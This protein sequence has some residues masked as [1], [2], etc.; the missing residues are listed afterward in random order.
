MFTMTASRYNVLKYYEY[1]R[2]NDIFVAYA[3]VPPASVKS[4]D[5]V[6]TVKQTS[7]PT[8][9]WGANVGF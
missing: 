3:I 9:K 2:T 5:S 7:L 6:V 8:S 1:A 4:A